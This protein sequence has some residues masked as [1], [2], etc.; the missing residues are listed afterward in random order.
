MFFKKDKDCAKRKSLND[1]VCNLEGQVKV[2]LIM[3]GGVFGMCATILG[4]LV[5]LR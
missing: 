3:V 4:L 5:V 2:L 1:R